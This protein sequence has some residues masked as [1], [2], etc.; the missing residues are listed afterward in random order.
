MAREPSPLV[1]DTAA[2]QGLEAERHREVTRAF[3]EAVTG[4]DEVDEGYRLRFPAERE[5]IELVAEFISRERLC[6]PFLS[7][8]L[9]VPA[10]ADSMECEITGPPGARELL[11]EVLELG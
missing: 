2:L 6:C 1:C 10:E 9:Q 4:F 3:R 8:R 5:R 7:F 11:R